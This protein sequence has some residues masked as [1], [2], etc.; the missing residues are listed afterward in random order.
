MS[1][2]PLRDDGTLT[3]SCAVKN[4]GQ[5]AGDEIAQMYVQQVASSVTTYEWNLRGFER[6]SLQPGE[7]KIVTFRMPVSFL[8]LINR[9]GKRVVEPGEFKV[10]VGASSTDLRLMGA[11]TVAAK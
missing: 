5:V 9:E 3:V 1:P 6:V 2:E 8:W 4:S 10:R 11:F 7:T